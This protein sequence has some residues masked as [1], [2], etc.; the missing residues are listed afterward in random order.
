MGNM[1]NISIWDDKWIL[2]AL[3]FKVTTLRPENAITVA[4]LINFDQANW[5][6]DLSRT[7]FN[8]I[9]P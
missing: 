3:N 1:Q 4:N 2:N 6:K 7:I 5:N 9:D 8:T